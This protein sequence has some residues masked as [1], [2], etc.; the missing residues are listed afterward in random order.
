MTPAVAVVRWWVFGG[1]GD[2]FTQAPARPPFPL[3][4]QPESGKPHTSIFPFSAY[5]VLTSSSPNPSSH[6]DGCLLGCS[7]SLRSTSFLPPPPPLAYPSLPRSSS[8]LLPCASSSGCQG[9]AYSVCRVRCAFCT[10]SLLVCANDTNSSSASSFLPP[11]S[12]LACCGY[13]VPFP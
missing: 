7:E 4:S 1:S 13:Q 12:I 9:F 11:P 5:Q 2:G 3:L 10:G 8:H 6:L